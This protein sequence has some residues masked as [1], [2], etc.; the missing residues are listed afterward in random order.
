MLVPC[1]QYRYMILRPF[2]LGN[3]FSDCNHCVFDG[4]LPNLYGVLVLIREELHLWCLAVTC[5]VSYLLVQLS[6]CQVT[7]DLFVEVIFSGCFSSVE[8]V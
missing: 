2:F 5:G 8:H 3:T 1:F 6:L 7:V 4:I